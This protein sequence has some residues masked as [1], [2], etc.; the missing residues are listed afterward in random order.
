MLV[1]P[2]DTTR[3]RNIKLLRCGYLALANLFSSTR[4]ITFDG[5]PIDG[6]VV[7]VFSD[8]PVSDQQFVLIIASATFEVVPQGQPI[9]ELSV[10]ITAHDGCVVW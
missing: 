1:V 2:S 9:P 8:W 5:F 7:G 3:G 10:T 4:H 6:I